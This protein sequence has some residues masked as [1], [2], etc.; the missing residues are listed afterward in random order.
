MYR[1]EKAVC[2]A[3][4]I[5][6]WEKA[7]YGRTIVKDPDVSWS[8]RFCCALL[9]EWMIPKEDSDISSDSAEEFLPKISWTTWPNL[10]T[11]I[12]PPKHPNCSDCYLF[13]TPIDVSQI[14]RKHNKHQVFL[15]L[16]TV[17]S[18]QKRAPRFGLKA[19][20]A[21]SVPYRHIKIFSP[22]YRRKKRWWNHW[23]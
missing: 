19:H 16:S 18:V 17:T 11:V 7:C 6:S 3:L 14:R 22:R 4:R 10:Y 5:P 13:S 9:T 8:I 23:F 21:T 15:I 12:S 20:K 1:C 2:R